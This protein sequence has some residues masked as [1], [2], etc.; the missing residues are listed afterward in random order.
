MKKIRFLFSLCLLLLCV[1]VLYARG[2]KEKDEPNPANEIELD[3][4]VNPPPEG[5]NEIRS[6]TVTGKVRLVGTGMFNELVISGDHEWYIAR[7]ERDKLHRLQQQTVTVEADEIIR[8]RTLL[9]NR[10]SIYR[11]ELSNIKI[12]SI[13]Q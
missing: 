7:D 4:G 10:G 2:G 3:L 1:T 9:N 11:W 13:E 5:L 8:E 12:I 6:V